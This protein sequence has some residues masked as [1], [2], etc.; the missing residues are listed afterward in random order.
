MTQF[1]NTEEF[2]ERLCQGVNAGQ[3]TRASFPDALTEEGWT[4]AITALAG[5]STVVKEVQVRP[6]QFIGILPTEQQKSRFTYDDLSKS[7]ASRLQLVK[8][9]KEHI[10]EFTAVRH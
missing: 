2:L 6:F 3:Y 5:Y 7:I 9:A 4:Q 10:K 1:T 8:F